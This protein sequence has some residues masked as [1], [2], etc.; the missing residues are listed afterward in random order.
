ML[1]PGLADDEVQPPCAEKVHQLASLRGLEVEAV[2]VGL[3]IALDIVGCMLQLDLRDAVW[4]D[5]HHNGQPCLGIALVGLIK[6]LEAVLHFPRRLQILR[7]GLPVRV[8]IVPLRRIAIVAQGMAGRVVCLQVIT[9]LQYI[10][11][12]Q[13]SSL[14]LV[15]EY[16]GF[17]CIPCRHLNSLPQCKQM[18]NG[19]GL[20][21]WPAVR[22]LLMTVVRRSCMQ[23]AH[24]RWLALCTH[25]EL[26]F[27]T[28]VCAADMQEMY[29][30]AHRYAK[31]SNARRIVAPSAA[32]PLLPSPGST[33]S[34]EGL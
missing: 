18:L 33:A 10:G 3:S 27:L 13:T 29:C 6:L 26:P 34:R 32:G 11:A 23:T 15:P 20:L 2:A 28:D 21:W 9:T 12:Y 30:R 31:L 16:N 22:Q 5:G 24:C 25:L 19:I 8:C 7:C 17:P 1:L 4:A 14:P